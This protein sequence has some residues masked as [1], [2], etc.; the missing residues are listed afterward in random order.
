M[1]K[2]FSV[3]IGVVIGAAVVS[4]FTWYRY[5]TNTESP[6][7]EIGIALNSHMPATLRDWGCAQLK[8][9]FG[10]GLP[11]HGCQAADGKAWAVP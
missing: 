6:Y 8:T 7:D 9:R 10:S 4:G 1:G 2:L 5:V 3:L 11:P